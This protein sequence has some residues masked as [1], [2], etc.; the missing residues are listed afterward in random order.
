M[1]EL[2]FFI[3][4]FRFLTFLCAVIFN[5][6]VMQFDCERHS[7]F[8]LM[9]KYVDLRVL[10][11]KLQIISAFALDHVKGF[12]YIDAEK[13]CDVNEACKGLCSIYSSR[14]SPVPRNE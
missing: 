8:C 3:F 12:V 10:G 6:L 5:F 1:K 2:N 4:H 9:Q 11:M 14:M 7:T 13:Q